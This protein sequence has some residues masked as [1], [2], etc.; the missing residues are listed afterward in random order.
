M[1]TKIGDDELREGLQ[2]FAAELGKKPTQ[3]EMR[4]DGPYS[5]NAY[6]RAFGSWNGA[7]E[8]AGFEPRSQGQ[9]IERAALLDALQDLANELGKT[10]T[11]SEVEELGKY[12]VGAYYAK[13]GSLNNA[14]EELGLEL[15]K[16]NNTDRIEVVCEHC[17]EEVERLPSQIKE[18]QHTYCSRECH[19]EHK[20]ERYSGAGNPR[21][22]KTE[23]S[24]DCCGDTILRAKWE[25]ERYER[26]YCEDCWGDAT[27]TVTC[28]WCGDEKEVWPSHRD[29]SDIYF[30]GHK[31]HGKWQSQTRR[32]E[33]H[34]RW[35]PG[36]RPEY[37]GPNWFEQ[38]RKAL[39]RDQHRCQDCGI[40]EAE[41][42]ESLSLHHIKP[43]R[44]FELD[45]GYDY[46]AAN[47][48]ENLVALCRPC[49]NTREA[50][51]DG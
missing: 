51:L 44:E 49:H 2:N 1:P 11:Q 20:E 33:D 39:K 28:E 29:Q 22:N 34:P 30:C 50:K 26:N 48:L 36:R 17:G 35:R 25:K 19:Y 38:R 6:K 5:I 23:V 4:L 15:N 42:G 46:E 18:N 41:F 43:F 24:C 8:E 13:F 3:K 31:C 40:T 37:Y 47:Q 14:K 7:L 16:E 21:Y 9:P 12:S 32:G 27:V 45:D 10:P